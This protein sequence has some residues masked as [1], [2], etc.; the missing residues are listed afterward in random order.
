CHPDEG[1]GVIDAV[2]PGV[3]GLAV[4][5]HVVLTTFGRALSDGGHRVHTAYV[6][7]DQ[8]AAV[9]IDED[10]PLDKAALVGCGITTTAWETA[11]NAAEVRPGQTVVVIGCGGVG[12]AA[13]QGA[14]ASGATEIVAVDPVEFKRD[15][16]LAF[17]ATH[18]VA[19]TD[20][21]AR[22]VVEVTRG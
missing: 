6:V 20:D 9:R 14:R 3:E 15:Q 12:T 5:D 13:L 7:V 21:A 1:A 4:G 18:A 10:I 2:G 17:G 22:Y 19:S 11:V 16:A 8:L